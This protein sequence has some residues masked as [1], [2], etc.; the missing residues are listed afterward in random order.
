MGARRIIYHRYLDNNGSI[1]ILLE[2]TEKEFVWLVIRLPPRLRGKGKATRFMR[3]VFDAVPGVHH[4]HF[5]PEVSS[6]RRLARRLH[7]LQSGSSNWIPDCIAFTYNSQP[8]KKATL[9]AQ[10]HLVHS[11][12]HTMPQLITFRNPLAAK[13]VIQRIKSDFKHNA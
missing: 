7:W 12:L 10:N 1:A 2:P 4:I 11:V 13:W 6:L 3:K 5:F 8:S 9:L